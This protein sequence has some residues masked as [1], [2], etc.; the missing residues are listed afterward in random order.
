MA[1][2][3][4]GLTILNAAYPF[5]P[6]GD[7][8]VGGAEQVLA[9]LDR[10]IC[11]AGHHS[12]VLAAE[13]SSVNGTL[14]P[15][16]KI[17]EQID[18]GQRK[19]VYQEYAATLDRILATE[20]IDLIHFHGIDFD[21]YLPAG[22]V[23]VLVTL[24]LP[25]EWYSTK[26]FRQSQPKLF[27]NCVSY[28]QRGRCPADVDAPVIENGVPVPE[29]IPRQNRQWAVSLG[30]IC[31]EKGFHLSL[32]AAQIA[33][34]DLLVG[35]YV[36][37]YVAHQKYFEREIVPRLSKGRGRFFGPVQHSQKENLLVGAKCLLAPSLAPETS[38]LVAME[39]L[40]Y[41]TPVIAFPAGALQ[42][43]VEDGRTGFLVNS[44]EEMAD[45]IGRIDEI[46]PEQCRKAARDR[47]SLSRMTTQYLNLYERI[48]SQ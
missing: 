45:A 1:S 2:S 11:D 8:A 47:F 3:P 16:G 9:Q 12:I 28:N 46:D 31:P 32:D 26:T 6:V 44:V 43:I 27:F 21:R 20:S 23:P 24:H 4:V 10:A 37:P 29:R 19:T 18:D 36:F 35:G 41:G 33:G 48:V 7:D 22:P 40:A 17:P 15:F 25:P 38:S 39:A 5:A 42:E 14:I 30:R 34:I 13:G